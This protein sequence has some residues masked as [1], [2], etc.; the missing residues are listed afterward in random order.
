MLQILNKKENMNDLIQVREEALQKM[1]TK[2]MDV[3]Q[4]ML[5]N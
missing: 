3:I 2:S 1:Q 5:D 4:K